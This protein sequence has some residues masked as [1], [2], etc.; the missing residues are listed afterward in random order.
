MNKIDL[1]TFRGGAVVDM[2]DEEMSKVLAN[3]EDENTEAKAKR[4][5]TI[6]LAIRP[7]KTRRGAS[8]DMQAKSA[9]APVRPVESLLFFDRDEEGRFSAYED[10]PGPMLTGI[11]ESENVKAFPKASGG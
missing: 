2:F 6:T 10:D 7:D 8:I 3:I 1:R 5:I 9:L 11:E 4:T